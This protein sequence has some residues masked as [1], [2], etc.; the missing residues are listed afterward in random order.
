MATARW[1]G[2][3]ELMG[4]VLLDGAH[5]PDGARAL[6]AA[7]EVLHPGRPVELV[8]GALADK[9]HR[10]ML[11]AL[12]GAVRRLHLVAPATPRARAVEDLLAAA[13]SLGMAAERYHGLT[14]AL[15]GAGAAAGDGAP[16]VVAGSL[17]LVG[18]ARAL[19]RPRNGT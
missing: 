2:R 14:E 18:E 11:A 5:N 13:A 17:Y 7:L 3:L 9:D 16:V 6:A 15:I 8:F 10:G 19:L 12:T 1:P 4:G